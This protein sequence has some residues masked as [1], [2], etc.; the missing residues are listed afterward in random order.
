LGESKVEYDSLNLAISQLLGHSIGKA[1]SIESSGGDHPLQEDSEYCIFSNSR[2]A[3]Y[4]RSSISPA[5][6]EQ[7]LGKDSIEATGSWTILSNACLVGSANVSTK[8]IAEFLDRL[9]ISLQQ[10]LDDDRSTHSD[11]IKCIFLSK[12]LSYILCHGGESSRYAFFNQSTVNLFTLVDLLTQ[13][14][15]EMD[16]QMSTLLL[17]REKD[18]LR[19]AAHERVSDIILFSLW[20]MIRLTLFTLVPRLI[21]RLEL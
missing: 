9:K 15:A 1:L 3:Q 16:P 12:A 11:S 18:D 20:Y 14:N 17:P 10:C 2:L 4:V 5:I 8:I 21:W 19:R 13:S 6:M 7:A